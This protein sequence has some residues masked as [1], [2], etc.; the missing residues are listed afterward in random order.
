MD[1]Y[2]NPVLTLNTYTLDELFKQLSYGELSNLVLAVDAAGVIK[3]ESRNRIV[4][5]ANEGLKDLHSRFLLQETLLQTTTTGAA[6]QL[7]LPDNTHSIVS[8][9]TEFGAPIEF[10]TIPR[11]DAAYFKDGLLVFPLTMGLPANWNLQVCLQMRHAVLTPVVADSD[12][13]QE[14]TLIPELRK[15]LTSYI[16]WHMY[17]VMNNADGIAIAD[18]HRGRYEQVCAEAQAHGLIPSSIQPISK[19]ELRG[20]V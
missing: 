4:H 20:F 19:L 16:A 7:L 8:I 10:D 14:I 3:K 18:R 9:F 11:T 2:T 17:E 15:A 13:K 5:F 12:L 1:I 6:M